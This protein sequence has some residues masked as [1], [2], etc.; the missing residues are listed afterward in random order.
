MLVLSQQNR[1]ILNGKDI[2]SFPLSF[3]SLN[4]KECFKLNLL[5]TSYASFLRATQASFAWLRW[6]T[7]PKRVF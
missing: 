2:S 3:I 1:F 4:F 5:F 7:T 6:K